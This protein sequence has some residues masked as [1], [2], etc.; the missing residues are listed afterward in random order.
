MSN[1]P[2]LAVKKTGGILF[3]AGLPRS[4]TSL[5]YALLNKH[6]DIALMYEAEIHSM[7]G[8]AWTVWGGRRMYPRL[9]FWNGVMSRHRISAAEVPSTLQNAEGLARW[10]YQTVRE[11]KSALWAGEKTPHS[12]SSLTLLADQYPDA[13]FIIINRDLAATVSSARRAAKNGALFFSSGGRIA[14]NFRMARVMY[15]SAAKMRERG[16]RLLFLDYNDLVDHP[17]RECRR[18]CEFLDL[19]WHPEMNRLDTSDRSAIP[20]GRHHS[21]VRGSAILR[22]ACEL[23]LS[24]QDHELCTRCE[25]LLDHDRWRAGAASGESTASGAPLSVR[26]TEW[27][28][29]WLLFNE[30]VKLQLLSLLPLSVWRWIREMRGRSVAG[31]PPPSSS[32]LSSDPANEAAGFGLTSLV[33]VT[34][35]PP[36]N[37]LPLIQAEFSRRGVSPQLRI[38]N[39]LAGLP[40]ADA[41][42]A[43]LDVSRTSPEQLR[44]L[45]ASVRGSGSKVAIAAFL[46]DGRC[47]L[48]LVA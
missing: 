37:P 13:R 5:L 38:V 39:E 45:T 21:Q 11:R 24:P 43:V 47:S 30:R 44:E 17:E 2:G 18:V 28:G 32:M 15:A 8:L 14:R 29:R 27:K 48:G 12:A 23:Q 35:S 1:F 3:V 9:D 36:E 33:I 42:P 25:T 20:P 31:S 16:R 6:P 41:A 26:W 19:P 22:T 4:G 34:G 7:P 10:C 46:S 40:D